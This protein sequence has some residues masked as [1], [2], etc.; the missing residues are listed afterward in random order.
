[1]G[2]N[3]VQV[4]TDDHQV[5]SGTD[6]STPTRG[7]PLSQMGRSR[8]SHS[9]TLRREG[10]QSLGSFHSTIP[11]RN[12]PRLRELRAAPGGSTEA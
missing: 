4:L 2:E 11:P 5:C 12:S 8:L 9:H 10:S 3:Q 1:M 7:H 6:V